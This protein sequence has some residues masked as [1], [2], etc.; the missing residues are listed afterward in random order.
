[1]VEFIK[2]YKRWLF[3]IIFLG[4]LIAFIER[5]Q[6]F[7][8]HRH[9]EVILAAAAKYAVDPALIKAVV[10][11]ESRFDSDAHGRSG[12]IGLMQIMRATADDWAGFEGTK[13]FR[14]SQLYAPAENV[15]C[16]AWYLK[17]LL[18]R[19]RDTDDPTV[20]ALAAYNAG[21]TTITKW[22]RGAGATNS[23]VFLEQMD[24]PATRKYVASVIRRYRYYQRE[25]VS[26]EK[27]A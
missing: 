10:W 13:G 27:K 6:N 11:Q 18:R 12:E 14:S 22:T 17:R 1:M 8:E 7:R 20:Y 3:A 19:Y 23:A 21:P 24:Y 4:G 5:W 2:R 9:D 25:F 16:G 26:A 15:R